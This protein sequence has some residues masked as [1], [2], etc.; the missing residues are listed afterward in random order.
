MS[1]T[2]GRS[3]SSEGVKS[4]QQFRGDA[5]LGACGGGGRMDLM[6]QAPL[7]GTGS[8]KTA[9]A[10]CGYNEDLN[11]YSLRHTGISAGHPATSRVME[12]AKLLLVVGFSV[13]ICWRDAV[14]PEFRRD[15]HESLV[16]FRCRFSSRNFIKFAREC[17][18]SLHK[19]LHQQQHSWCYVSFSR[20]A[21]S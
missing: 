11:V 20:G 14:V 4:G 2:D 19:M 8:S 5:C 18:S 16:A 7:D 6:G 17:R 10:K 13:L 21:V 9:C 3:P 12:N 1:A 15:S